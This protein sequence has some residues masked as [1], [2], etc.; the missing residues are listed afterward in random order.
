MG[1]AEDSDS[2]KRGPTPCHWSGMMI[3]SIDRGSSTDV[4]LSY[5]YYESD[6]N[7]VDALW[8]VAGFD[9]GHDHFD[10]GGPGLLARPNDFFA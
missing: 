7:A 8:I 5:P 4:G 2:R 9:P 6:W 3:C 10:C 1:D